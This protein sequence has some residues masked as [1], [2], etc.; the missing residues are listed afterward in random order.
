M[1]RW[2]GGPLWPLLLAAWACVAAGCR[3]SRAPVPAEPANPSSLRYGAP[4]ADAGPEARLGEATLLGGL[5][6]RGPVGLPEL[7]AWLADRRN[8]EPLR[9]VLP[10]GL[11][12]AE[13]LLFIPPENP[14][15]RAKIEL[16][17]Q[18]FFDR[19][20]S[21]F[22]AFACATCHRP[23]QSFAASTVFPDS[24]R[25]PPATILRVLS[26]RQFW[27]G[28]AASLEDQA[29]TPIANPFEMNT[30]PE[31]YVAKLR[32]IPGY[33]LQFEA[34]FG[35]VEFVGA[36]QA[37]ACFQRM[38]VP[39]PTPWDFARSLAALESRADTLT[40]SER[41]DRDALRGLA[42]RQP[43]S[44]EARRGA[45]L[46]FGERTN[47]SDCHTGPNL[48][49]ESFHRLGANLPNQRPDAGRFLVTAR[50]SDREAFKTPT[51]RQI[52]RT[53]PYLHNGRFRTLEEVVD[54]FCAGG[55]P[56]P[57]GD[58][59]KLSLAPNERQDLLAFLRSL[60]SDLP[61]VEAGRLPD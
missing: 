49:D 14:L 53:P 35:G 43:L 54:W 21:G 39:A 20:L 50:E 27:D 55:G 58:L 41:A 23:D 9:P 11:R 12:D 42:E 6:G 16:G 25:S 7:R 36:A 8:H 13:P 10:L 18:L 47:C 40:E 57:T 26:T 34:I 28:R 1:R 56:G 33:R 15:T 29:A 4:A 17:R 2:P 51:L 19:R 38:L 37:L 22:E 59:K 61:E 30:T 32:A 45:E 60:S 24:Q 46:F 3:D 5:P 31:A 52:A 48:T 44:P